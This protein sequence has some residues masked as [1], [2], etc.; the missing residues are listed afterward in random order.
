MV[1]RRERQEVSIVIRSHETP[2][3]GAPCPLVALSPR[4]IDVLSLTCQ[5]RRTSEIA[6]QLGLSLRT[7]DSY[8][9]RLCQGLA[10]RGR[11][12]L[13]V[14]GHQNPKALSGAPAHPGLH[15]PGCRCG[16]LSCSLGDAA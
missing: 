16:S 15:R 10:L 7:V 2:R 6:R 1:Y 14:W 3:P 4:E 9:W 13:M 5:G 11:I 8:I 12:E